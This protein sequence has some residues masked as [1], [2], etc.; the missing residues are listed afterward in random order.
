MRFSYQ[1]AQLSP[2]IDQLT[3]VSTTGRHG[4]YIP[5]HLIVAVV[6][7]SARFYTLCKSFLRNHTAMRYPLVSLTREY[8]SVPQSVRSSELR[9]DTSN[10]KEWYD[11]EMACRCW[12][13]GTIPKVKDATGAAR[14][15]A[16]FRFSTSVITQVN[17]HTEYLTKMKHL[18]TLLACAKM[19][20]YLEDVKLQKI[21]KK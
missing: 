6:A 1:R 3:L 17:L 10:S 15:G 13:V 9:A 16:T 7:C 2:H 18:K 8:T 12:S 21:K 11:K 4:C 14:S 5:D 19:S 20:G